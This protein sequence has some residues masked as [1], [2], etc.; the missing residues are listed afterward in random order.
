MLERCVLLHNR[1]A[2]INPSRLEFRALR[3][4]FLFCKMIF[5]MNLTGEEV[6]APR[7]CK[8]LF[9]EESGSSDA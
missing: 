8:L 7:I 5:C 1:P 2:N 9:K 4:A 6:Y 3:S